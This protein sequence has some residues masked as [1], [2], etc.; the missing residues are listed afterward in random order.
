MGTR[1]P[2]SDGSSVVATSGEWFA[3]QESLL[4]SPPFPA[5]FLLSSPPPSFSFS[6][7]SPECWSIP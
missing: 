4:P 1:S 7:L 6:F 3:C 5:F 2:C